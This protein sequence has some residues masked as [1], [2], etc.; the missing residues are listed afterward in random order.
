MPKLGLIFDSSRTVRRIVEHISYRGLS[1]LCRDGV[2]P[3]SA[4]ALGTQQEDQKKAS[5]VEAE[6]CPRRGVKCM[7]AEIARWLPRA[8]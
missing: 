3:G 1:L 8:Q 6:G 5:L 2:F 4:G 7:H